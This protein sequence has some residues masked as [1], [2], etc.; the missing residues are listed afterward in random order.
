MIRS[1][2]IVFALQGAEIT[3][4]AYLT[5][6]DKLQHV[7]IEKICYDGIDALKIFDIM[8]QQDNLCPMLRVLRIQLI[9]EARMMARCEV[10]RI[11]MEQP[12]I[13]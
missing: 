3:A 7:E 5:D 6:E 10:E 9:R 4:L 13:I 12:S 2:K 11:Y 1:E 8:K